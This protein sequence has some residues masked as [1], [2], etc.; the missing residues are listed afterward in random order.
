MAELTPL[1]VPC[2]ICSEELRIRLHTKGTSAKAPTGP[3]AAVFIE[4]DSSQIERHIA[5]HLADLEEEAA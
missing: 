5:A 4:A 2:P 3:T 1:P